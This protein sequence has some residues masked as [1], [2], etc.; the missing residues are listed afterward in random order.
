MGRP[1]RKYVVYDI[2]RCRRMGEYEGYMGSFEC[3]QDA[4]ELSYRLAGGWK[5]SVWPNDS[6]SDGSN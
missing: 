2:E 4:L 5:I 1:D 3:F 6:K